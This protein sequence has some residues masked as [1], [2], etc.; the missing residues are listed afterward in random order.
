MSIYLDHLIIFVVFCFYSILEAKMSERPY[1]GCE[2]RYPASARLVIIILVRDR[3]FL[4]KFFSSNEC[5]P[6]PYFI[7]YV[8]VGLSLNIRCS[9]LA[10]LSIPN[11]T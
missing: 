2:M 10:G 4:L 1:R 3:C 8:K 5:S 6:Q 11:I 7:N 9:N